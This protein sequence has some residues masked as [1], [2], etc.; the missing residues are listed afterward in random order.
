MSDFCPFVRGQCRDDCQFHWS[1]DCAI[2]TVLFII[3][4]LL[5]PLWD[6]TETGNP[7]FFP[8]LPVQVVQTGPQMFTCDI[9]GKSVAWESATEGVEMRDGQFFCSQSCVQTN[10]ARRATRVAA[11]KKAREDRNDT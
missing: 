5:T 1:G 4:E 7:P 8:V 6:S 2:A 3:D 11:W 9:C 10:D